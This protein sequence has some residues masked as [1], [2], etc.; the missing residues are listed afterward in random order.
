VA[1]RIVRAV[2]RGRRR[3]VMDRLNDLGLRLAGALPELE[4]AFLSFVGKRVLRREPSSAKAPPDA[5]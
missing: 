3:V 2:I 5:G 1:R 4:G